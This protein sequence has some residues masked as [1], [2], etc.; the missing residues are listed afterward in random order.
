MTQRVYPGSRRA[1][2]RL[3]E[4]HLDL[5]LPHVR[6]PRGDCGEGVTSVIDRQRRRWVLLAIGRGRGSATARVDGKGAGGLHAGSAMDRAG[7]TDS[8]PWW[9]PASHRERRGARLARRDERAYRTYVS[10][11]ASR[12]AFAAR[13][14]AGFRHGLLAT[15]VVTATVC[16][17]SRRGRSARAVSCFSVRKTGGGGG[18]VGEDRTSRLRCR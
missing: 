4:Y 14:Q 15:A 3:F 13:M 8:S 9:N 5:L 12:D 7:A 2:L 17:W 10:N 1:R 11:A 16:A 6:V 18:G